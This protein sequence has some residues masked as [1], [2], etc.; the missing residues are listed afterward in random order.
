M[1]KEAAATKTTT[2][3]PEDD[4]I[5]S[6]AAAYFRFRLAVVVGTGSSSR[7]TPAKR[8]SPS[9]LA[10]R[11]ATT[12]C[13][14]EQHAAGAWRIKNRNVDEL[15]CSLSGTVARGERSYDSIVYY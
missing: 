9:C 1:V 14:Q 6:R 15:L 3:I 5:A 12:S 11:G 4:E 7:V 2:N 10:R 13:H 8:V